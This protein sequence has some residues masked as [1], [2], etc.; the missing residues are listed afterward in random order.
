MYCMASGSPVRS[1]I[2]RVR[3]GPG[4]NPNTATP[5]PAVSAATDSVKLTRAALAQP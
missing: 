1:S 3:I 4:A 2:R 5:V